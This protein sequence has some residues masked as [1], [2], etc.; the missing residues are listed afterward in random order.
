MKK[1]SELKFIDS[2][3]TDKHGQLIFA[4]YAC[5]LPEKKDINTDTF[6]K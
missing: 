3:G 6:I 5:R 4:I 2:Y 1:L